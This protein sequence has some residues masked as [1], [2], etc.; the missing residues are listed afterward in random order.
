MKDD[1]TTVYLEDYPELVP[2]GHTGVHD[3]YRC[4]KCLSIRGKDDK[5]G[6]LYFN[7]I[8]RVGMCFKCNTVMRS[9]RTMNK[10]ELSEYLE[11]NKEQQRIEPAV[12]SLSFATPI[13]KGSDACE[14]LTSR[15]LSY[16]TI[17]EYDLR[18]WNSKIKGIVF[19]NGINDACSDILQIRDYKTTDK[20]RRFL[21]VKDVI[22]PLVYLKQAGSSM[23]LCEG[24]MS[25]LSSYEYLSDLGVRPIISMGKTMSTYQMTQLV[26]HSY[27]FEEV[28]LT[29]CYDGGFNYEALKVAHDI[30]DHV[31]NIRLYILRLP[32]DKDP[33]DLS[34]EEF[35]E[36]Y[37]TRRYKY[38]HSVHTYL[39]KILKELN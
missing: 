35:R 4:P 33:N 5:S 38:T 14:Y 6:K 22:K 15:G 39:M 36:Y 30:L 19:H 29:I 9:S 17:T 34:R 23:I 27:K 2:V 16:S 8:K 11:Y 20:S 1:R 32:N 31:S 13:I 12:L 21:N 25:G 3:I 18:E 24:F 37:C 7:T 28:E 10:E 26:E